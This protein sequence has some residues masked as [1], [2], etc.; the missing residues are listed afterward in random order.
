[1]NKNVWVIQE[2]YYPDEVAGAYFMTKLAEGLSVY[3]N[4][5]VLC[6]YPV[7]NARGIMVPK[8]ERLNGWM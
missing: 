5:N 6:G 3:Y 8:H 2:V 1:M 7:Y 4:V